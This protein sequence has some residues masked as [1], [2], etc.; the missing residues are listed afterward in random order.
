MK[1]CLIPARGGSKRIKNKNIK[2][3]LGKPIIA[4]SI[5]KAKKSKLFDDIVVSTD[6][7]K[8]ANIAKKFGA[9]VPFLRP[10]KLANDYAIDRDVLHHYLDYACK[11]KIKIKFLCYLYPTIPLLKISTLKKCYNLIKKSNSPKVITTCKFNYPIQRALKRNKRG[12][13]KFSDRK[14]MFFRSQNLKEEYHYDAGHCYWYN[15]N[16]YNKIR[17]RK[18]IKTLSIILNNYEV[19]DINT[20]EEFRLAERLFK[21]NKLKR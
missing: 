12:E 5:Q 18:K 4:W 9:S 6:S 7:K 17:N 8:I 2:N 19:Q 1:I 3:F 15:L 13:V 10:K 16:E 21:F 14:F 20:I 11:K